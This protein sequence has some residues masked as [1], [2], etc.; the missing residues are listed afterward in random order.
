MIGSLQEMVLGKLNSHMQ[1]NDTG[2][3]YYTTYKINSKWTKKLNE[4]SETT[5]FLEEKT[6]SKFLDIGFGDDFFKI[7]QQKQ[8]Q[9]KQK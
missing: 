2:P 5:K 7:G 6:I 9:Q 1:K 8:R 3:P 4:K